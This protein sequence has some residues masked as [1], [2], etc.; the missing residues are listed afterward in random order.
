MALNDMNN[1]K[2]KNKVNFPYISVLPFSI[3]AKLPKEVNEISKFFEKNPSPN[4]NKKLYAQAFSNGSNFNSTN[5]ARE[6]LKIKEAFPSLQNK[7]IKQIHKIISGVTQ[8]N[9]M[10]CGDTNIFLFLLSIFLDFIF[11]FF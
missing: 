8:S 10:K 6:T 2:E 7:K 1:F 11:L 9:V 4:V 5:T 3:L